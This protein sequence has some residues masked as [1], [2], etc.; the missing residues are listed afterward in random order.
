[1]TVE[2]QTLTRSAR[3]GE[4]GLG[5]MES[6]WTE[7]DLQLMRRALTQASAAVL[8]GEGPVVARSSPKT[9]GPMRRNHGELAT[10]FAAIGQTYPAR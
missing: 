3:A 1:M 6:D 5:E 8:T 10:S 4:T 2:R 9:R 7:R